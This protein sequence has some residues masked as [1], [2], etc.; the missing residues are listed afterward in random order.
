LIND[1]ISDD[2]IKI[3][4]E[5]NIN[6]ESCCIVFSEILFMLEEEEDN[7][8]AYEIFIKAYAMKDGSFDKLLIFYLRYTLSFYIKQA[9]ELLPEEEKN[10]INNTNIFNSC[11]IESPNI[12]P[13]F[14]DICCFQYLFDIKI[15][16]IYLQG[17]ISNPV[18]RSINLIG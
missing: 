16:L 9:K 4:D 12:E 14:L 7:N 3:Y 10:N 15:N 18:Q 13:S 1:I 17:G 11:A 6:M 2:K 8:K 5:K